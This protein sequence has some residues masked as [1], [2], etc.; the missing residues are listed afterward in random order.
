[1]Q[2]E[3]SK[4][5]L[6]SV[7]VS[8]T[9][10]PMCNRVRSCFLDSLA[11]STLLVASAATSIQAQSPEPPG[12][13]NARFLTNGWFQLEIDGSAPMGYV[14]ERSEVL[15][16]WKDAALRLRADILTNPLPF[17]DGE[18]VGEARF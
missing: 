7:C 2:I 16:S 17:I 8:V 14:I 15:G 3:G 5:S 1:M 13:A 18:G 12:I 11:L 9:I 6:A 4:K 10:H